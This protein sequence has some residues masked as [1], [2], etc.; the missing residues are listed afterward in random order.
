MHYRKNGSSSRRIN[1]FKVD[2]NKILLIH[3]LDT[4][5]KILYF[6]KI[7]FWKEFKISNSSLLPLNKVSNG[8]TLFSFF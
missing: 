6:I 7:K 3:D 2:R 8:L 1:M 5:P 4:S